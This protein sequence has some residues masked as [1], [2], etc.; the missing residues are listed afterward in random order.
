VDV[1]RARWVVPVTS[2]PVRDGAVAVRDG[3][4]AYVGPRAS[5]P[6]GKVRDL[7]DTLLLPGLVNTHT[8]LELTAMR[9]FLENLPFADWIARLQVA[10]TSVLTPASMLDAA[11][12]GIAEGLLAGITTYADTCDSGVALEAMR[13]MGV[14]GIMYQ[15]VF[16]PDPDACDEAVAALRRKI[17]VHRAGES[18][19]VRVGVSPHAPFTV[20]DALFEAVRDLA[21]AI[22]VPMAIHIAESADEDAYVR[23][24]SGPFADAHRA[25]GISVAPRGDTPVALLDRLGVLSERPLLI[26]CVRAREADIRIIAAARCPIAHCPASNAKLGHGI[27]PLIEWLQ[28]G[29][30]V[31][32]GSDSMASNNRMHLLEEARLALL[33][34]R[35]RGLAPTAFTPSQ[36]LELATLG[37]ARCLGLADEVGSIEVGK[38]ADFAAF[39]LDELPAVPSTD[40]V[41]TAVFALGGARARAVAVAGELRVLDGRVL[42]MDD[43]LVVRVRAT[44]DAL[45]ASDVSPRHSSE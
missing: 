26:H 7:G 33:A 8:H 6:K 36:A 32:L 30:T 29:I 11:K 27:A 2:L 40:P 15:E 16:G 5:A 14:R 25:R 17:E 44:G 19:L 28:A 4:C 20:S 12:L 41:A 31:G 38:S 13:A 18:A 37:G 9:G 23:D 34:Q 22:N 1:F 10:K 21:R 45:R 39:P 35:G 3:R 43:D 24:A 42:D